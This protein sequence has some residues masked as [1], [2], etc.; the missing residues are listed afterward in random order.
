MSERTS[1]HMISKA[2]A[3]LDL[4]LL[5]SLNAEDYRQYRDH[6][7]N[8][9][10]YALIYFSDK[11][12]YEYPLL[13][14]V[15]K[16]AIKNGCSAIESRGPRHYSAMEL[17]LHSENR[18]FLLSTLIESGCDPNHINPQ[19][20]SLLH[21]ANTP[22]EIDCAI[23]FGTNPQSIDRLGN[24]PIFNYLAGDIEY[25]R[26]IKLIDAGVD[27]DHIND[28]GDSS[29]HNAI[30][31][32]KYYKSIE[33]AYSTSS[34]I[35]SQVDPNNLAI[36]GKL[37]FANYELN[38]LVDHV[39]YA[40]KAGANASLK[41]GQRQTPLDLLYSIRDHPKH[42]EILHI[43]SK[44]GAQSSTSWLVRKQQ[45]LALKVSKWNR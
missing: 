27:I 1:I 10:L 45:D 5:L 39:M 19:E 12:K 34:R 30:R 38:Y 43:L 22:E 9:L 4:D 14:T 24:S 3:S 17:S 35:D 13:A 8:N 16:L 6:N 29:I 31:A 28:F 32:T 36:V 15:I 23:K 7:N 41:N 18:D 44:H 2:L 11:K 33:R 21:S 40:L 37:M 25:Q 26:I 20:F 42:F